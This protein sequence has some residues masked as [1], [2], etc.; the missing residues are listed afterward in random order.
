MIDLLAAL[1]IIPIVTGWVI[2]ARTIWNTWWRGEVNVFHIYSGGF[3][4]ALC[5]CSFA[6]QVSI[7]GLV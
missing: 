2:V 7:R 6:L 1:F 3:G 5:I 4:F